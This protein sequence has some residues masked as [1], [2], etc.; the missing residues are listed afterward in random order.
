MTV[1]LQ[2]LYTFKEGQGQQ[3]RDVGGVGQP[4]NLRIA[5]ASRVAWSSTGLEVKAAT[6]ITSESPARKIIDTCRASNELTLEAW[7]QPANISQ[8]LPQA[9]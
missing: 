8:P 9:V 2:T 1:G 6:L 3:V 4:L 7:V 5:N